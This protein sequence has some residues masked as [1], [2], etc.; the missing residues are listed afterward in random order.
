[1]FF[2]SFQMLYSLIPISLFIYLFIYLEVGRFSSLLNKTGKNMSF[3]L[4]LLLLF[5]FFFLQ[6]LDLLFAVAMKF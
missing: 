3:L 2:P 5:L 1:M 4:L 6:L